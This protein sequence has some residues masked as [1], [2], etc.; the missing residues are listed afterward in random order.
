[1]AGRRREARPGQPGA[2]CAFRTQMARWAPPT[3]WR[4]AATAL[5][6]PSRPCAI[7]V[8]I[9]TSF[10]GS[11]VLVVEGVAGRVDPPVEVGG[12]ACSNGGVGVLASV[13]RLVPAELDEGT[14][15]RE[16]ESDGVVVF[17]LH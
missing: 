16:L 12:L 17:A 3:A 13:E 2:V 5:A 4:A 10:L 8:G 6:T 1:M 7:A 11:E 9:G 15:K 14:Q